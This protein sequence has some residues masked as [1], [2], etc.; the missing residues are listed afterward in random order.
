MLRICV[1]N[2]GEDPEEVDR[3]QMVKSLC[4]M[5][6]CAQGEKETSHE[7]CVGKKRPAALQTEE[8]V[9]ADAALNIRASHNCILQHSLVPSSKKAFRDLF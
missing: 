9:R 7:I 1:G 6:R 3:D 2:V 4:A 5:A 8:E